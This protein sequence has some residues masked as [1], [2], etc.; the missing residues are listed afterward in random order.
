[1]RDIIDKYKE[2]FGNRFIKRVTEIQSLHEHDFI[3]SALTM[4]LILPDVCASY[5]Y[6]GEKDHYGA[7]VRYMD[8]VNANMSDIWTIPLPTEVEPKKNDYFSLGSVLYSLRN[9]FAHS[10]SDKVQLSS[11][12]QLDFGKNAG[13]TSNE[14]KNKSESI[15]LVFNVIDDNKKLDPEYIYEP[16]L[17]IT[18]YKDVSIKIDIVSFYTGHWGITSDVQLHLIPGSVK[19]NDITINIHIGA[20]DL[21]KRLCNAAVQYYETLSDDDKSVMNSRMASFIEMDAHNKAMYGWG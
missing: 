8:W 2:D 17:D 3:Y 12:V 19:Y 7:G 4:A 18:N 16:E 13:N 6:Q 9:S 11:S 14:D 20:P 21:I 10:L 1:M 5:K 15:Q